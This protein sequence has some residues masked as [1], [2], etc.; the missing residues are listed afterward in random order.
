M[1][2]GSARFSEDF[3]V[4]EPIEGRVDACRWRSH[5]GMGTWTY[6]SQGSGP[7]HDVVFGAVCGHAASCASWPH[8]QRFSRWLARCGC[9][10]SRGRM[11]QWSHRGVRSRRRHAALEEA[12]AG[13]VGHGVLEQDVSVLWGGLVRTT[14][15]LGH[16]KRSGVDLRGG[17]MANLDPVGPWSVLC[18]A[19]VGN[20]S[21]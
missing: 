3:R 13:T 19:S 8:S 9:R 18:D 4:L 15:S 20:G 11:G 21:F 2:Y 12:F 7:W 1:S 5:G 17:V 16:A 14:R 10:A 6:G